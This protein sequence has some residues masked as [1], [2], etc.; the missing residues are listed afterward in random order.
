MKK[1]EHHWCSKL[2]LLLTS[3][4]PNINCLCSWVYKPRLA[5]TDTCC[6]AD[7][8]TDRIRT[9]QEI[10]RTCSHMM[11]TSTTVVQWFWMLSLR[12]RMR[13]TLRWRFDDLAARASVDHVPWPLMVLTRWHAS[14]LC[15]CSLSMFCVTSLVFRMVSHID[16]QGNTIKIQWNTSKVQRRRWLGHSEIKSQDKDIDVKILGLRHVGYGKQK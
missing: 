13:W 16:W 8:A 15:C 2:Q 4:L 3:C 12:S 5:N 6:C 14:G 7:C 11:L 10:S 1:A 9:S